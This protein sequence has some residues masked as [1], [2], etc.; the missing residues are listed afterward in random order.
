MTLLFV[1]ETR[2]DPVKKGGVLDPNIPNLPTWKR[3][4]MISLK[5]MLTIVSTL[6]RHASRSAASG[7]ASAQA[8]RRRGSPL[9]APARVDRRNPTF[10]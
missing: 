4:I 10:F 1:P 5:R 3:S 6:Q 8:G 9:S 7:P 2:P